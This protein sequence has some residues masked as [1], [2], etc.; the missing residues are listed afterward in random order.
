M[1]SEEWAKAFLLRFQNNRIESCS[2]SPTYNQQIFEKRKKFRVKWSVEGV[3]TEFRFTRSQI[4]ELKAISNGK[5][6]TT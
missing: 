5:G 6:N 4:N 1:P 3:A 2:L